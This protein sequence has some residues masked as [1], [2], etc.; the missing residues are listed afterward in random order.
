MNTSI[1]IEHEHQ[2][3]VI[4]DTTRLPVLEIGKWPNWLAMWVSLTAYFT[5][6]GKIN[7]L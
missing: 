5:M 7:L 4:L 3:H 1:R 2:Y 6:G